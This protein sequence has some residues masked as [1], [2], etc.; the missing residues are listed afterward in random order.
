[1]D[2]FQHGQVATYLPIRKLVRETKR[3][4]NMEWVEHL[5]IKAKAMVTCRKVVIHS[6]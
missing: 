6:N 3:L 4:K 2:S 5:N 1:M